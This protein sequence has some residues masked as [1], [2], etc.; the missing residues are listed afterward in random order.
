MYERYISEENFVYDVSVC[1]LACL[2][3]VSSIAVLVNESDIL[4]EHLDLEV[5]IVELLMC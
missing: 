4:E 1:E 2:A 5:C 3:Y